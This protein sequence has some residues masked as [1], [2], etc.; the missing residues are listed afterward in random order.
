MLDVFDGCPLQPA[1]AIADKANADSSHRNRRTVDV[2]MSL[3]SIWASNISRYRCYA[4]AA[5][6]RLPTPP[7]SPAQ[8]RHSYDASLWWGQTENHTRLA[9]GT[10]SALCFGHVQTVPGSAPRTLPSVKGVVLLA[11]RPEPSRRWPRPGSLRT[12]RMSSHD[13]R[14]FEVDGR[15]EHA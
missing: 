6:R 10:P 14:S 5:K 7:S 2:R 3:P 12:S 15:H 11:T 13:W 4:S 8:Q 1:Q 9:N